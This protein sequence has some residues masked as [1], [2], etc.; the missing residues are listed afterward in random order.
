MKRSLSALPSLPFP[1]LH[2]YDILLYATSDSMLEA[3]WLKRDGNDRR[4][5]WPSAD[6]PCLAGLMA[7]CREAS[8]FPA[9]GPEL[10]LVLTTPQLEI[11]ENH[12]KGQS[13]G[14]L[15]RVCHSEGVMLPLVL[16]ETG[17]QAEEWES[18]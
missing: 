1:L 11:H 8:S 16:A 5:L 13:K 18:F 10:E 12:P 14:Y 6:Q 2:R 15:F 3:R 9:W 7:P 4:S 17:K